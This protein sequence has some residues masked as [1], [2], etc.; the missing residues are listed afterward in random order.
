VAVGSANHII[1]VYDRREKRRPVYETD[2][3][4][5]PITALNLK[6]NN[7]SLFV[8]NSAG[9]MSEI[10]LRTGKQLGAFKGNCGSIRSIVCHKTQP[11][12]AVCGLDRV[13][14]LYDMNR[15][16]VKQVKFCF[17]TSLMLKYIIPS[18]MMLGKALKVQCGLEKLLL[19][20]K[21]VSKLHSATSL[22]EWLLE[23]RKNENV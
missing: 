19:K 8:G 3:H 6:P 2:W 10:D 4:E 11:Y 17:G 5:H 21:Y 22:D 23:L 20:Q 13:L 15:K 16:I 1:R 12:I 18:I 14:K 7:H 9:H